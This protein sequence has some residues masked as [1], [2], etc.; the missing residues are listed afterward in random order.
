MQNCPLKV[1]TQLLFSGPLRV[2]IE[3][4]MLTMVTSCSDCRQMP[5]FKKTVLAIRAVTGQAVSPGNN[6]ANGMC[7]QIKRPQLLGVGTDGDRG[8]Q[9]AIP[10]R[11]CVLSTD[12]RN[13]LGS[14]QLQRGSCA[15]PPHPQ[16]SLYV[17]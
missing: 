14:V 13:V 16:F 5:A 15:T 7:C 3:I 10:S 12:K 17:G 2:N 11:R 9:Q 8:S 4:A 6:R 1:R